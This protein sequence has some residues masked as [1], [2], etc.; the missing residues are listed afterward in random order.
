VLVVG[1]PVALP[2]S[3]PPCHAR[4]RGLGPQQPKRAGL[5]RPK[6]LRPAKIQW[7]EKEVVGPLPV[8]LFVLSYWL[9]SQ[10]LV[11]DGKRKCT[12]WGRLDL[13]DLVCGKEFICN[14]AVMAVHKLKFSIS[15]SNNFVQKNC[16]KKNC[17]D[18]RKTIQSAR[19]AMI[20]R[21]SSH[22]MTSDQ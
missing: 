21:P 22:S 18:E 6:L 1:L 2:S 7:L 20:P 11:T 19:S 16:Q 15:V 17:Q 14:D 12:S 10:S 3:G 8:T 9:S 5:R 4:P 13:R